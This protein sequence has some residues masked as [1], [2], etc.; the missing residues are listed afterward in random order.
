MARLTYTD[1]VRKPMDVLDMTS[2]TPDEFPAISPS[3]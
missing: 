3:L 2:L 1:L